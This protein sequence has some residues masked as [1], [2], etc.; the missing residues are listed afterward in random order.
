SL[1]NLDHV[2][3]L[4]DRRDLAEVFAAAA[5][6]LNSACHTLSL[7][8]GG[9]RPLQGLPPRLRRQSRRPK[10]PPSPRETLGTT[11]STPSPPAPPA[12]SPYRRP[13]PRAPSPS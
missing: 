5:S 9:Y 12:Y 6:T 4:D 10:T 2:R 11:S 1:L 8:G 3:D 13:P 7:I